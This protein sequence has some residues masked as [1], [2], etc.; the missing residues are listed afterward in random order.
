MSS[1]GYKQMGFVSL[2]SF[3]IMWENRKRLPER[4]LETTEGF[5]VDNI[6]H[7]RRREKGHSSD[8]LKQLF[9]NTV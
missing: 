3:I 8:G 1:F 2:A 6:L 4:N 9:P 5:K 7:K